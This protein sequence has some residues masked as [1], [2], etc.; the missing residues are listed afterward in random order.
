MPSTPSCRKPTAGGG[1]GCLSVKVLSTGGNVARG[2]RYSALFPLPAPVGVLAGCTSRGAYVGI[3]RQPAAFRPARCCSS[4]SRP[5]LRGARGM[6]SAHAVNSGQG[7]LGARPVLY[8]V[9]SPLA[10]RGRGR[11]IVDTGKPPRAGNPADTQPPA[12]LARACVACSCSLLKVQAPVGAG[13]GFR[14]PP[15]RGNR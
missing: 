15:L 11:R 9:F 13:A 1:V 5:P 10:G 4:Q 6:I 8:H 12:L 14:L 2:F 7:T 3:T